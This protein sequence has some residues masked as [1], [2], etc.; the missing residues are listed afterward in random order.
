[1][2]S[3]RGVAVAAAA[4]AAL[5]VVVGA[6]IALKREG[7]IPAD[8]DLI[9]FSCKEPKNIWY[10]ICIANSDGG[11]RRR[12]TRRLAVAHDQSCVVTGW[13]ADRLHA[14]RRCRRVR[15]TKRGRR[16]RHGCGRR[17]SRATDPG[18]SRCAL[19]TTCLVPRP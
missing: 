19:W 6:F 1:M 11:E 2:L 12:T 8:G 7:A 9:A 18:P 4:L 15:D 16:L 17:R 3:R 5:V 10:A 13:T 14:Q